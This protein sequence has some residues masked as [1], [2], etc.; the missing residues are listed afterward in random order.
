MVDLNKLGLQVLR[1]LHM[2]CMPVNFWQASLTLHVRK[3]TKGMYQ[4]FNKAL[5]AAR[6]L[7]NLVELVN[8][9]WSCL[10]KRGA[11]KN[12]SFLLPLSFCFS[13]YGVFIR[14]AQDLVVTI[15]NL[16]IKVDF[17]SFLHSEQLSPKIDLLM[18]TWQGRCLLTLINYCNY[19]FF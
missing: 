9:L 5:E 1:Y 4:W 14:E 10:N 18:S 16:W 7:S 15:W 3:F 11:Q 12:V 13:C 19:V 8:F 17:N 6:W 2:L